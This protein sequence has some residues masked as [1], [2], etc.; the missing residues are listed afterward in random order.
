MAFKRLI[1]AYGN[2]IF[3]CLNKSGIRIIHNHSMNI[4]KFPVKNHSNVFHIKCFFM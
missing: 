3:N 4:N 2:L 1:V